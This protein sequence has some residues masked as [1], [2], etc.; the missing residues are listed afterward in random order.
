MFVVVSDHRSRSAQ[1]R[2]LSKCLNKLRE[3]IRGCFSQ[4]GTPSASVIGTSQF[5][6][7]GFGGWQGQR[8]GDIDTYLCQ[9]TM[10][11]CTTAFLPPF[12]LHISF[13]LQISCSLTWNEIDPNHS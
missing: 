7:M 11:F 6:K 10:D 8:C 1:R 13:V 3:Q 5:W 2:N 9:G 12:G 4:V